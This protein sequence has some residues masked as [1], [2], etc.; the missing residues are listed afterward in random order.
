MKLF[1]RGR[2][3]LK[4]ITTSKKKCIDC[5]QELNESRQKQVRTPNKNKLV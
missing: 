5:K 4:K 1:K 2:S 3:L